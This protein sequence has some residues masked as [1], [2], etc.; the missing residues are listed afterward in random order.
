M[1]SLI[2]L[3]AKGVAWVAHQV[4]ELGNSGDKFVSEVNRETL[5]I[6]HVKHHNH[7][8]INGWAACEW[9]R[10]DRGFD[11]VKQN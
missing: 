4:E 3:A 1:D 8:T 9:C 5:R 2:K 10:K 11:A 6:E 7:G